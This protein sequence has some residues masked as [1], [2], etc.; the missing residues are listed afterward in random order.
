MAAS[1]LILLLGVQLLGLIAATATSAQESAVLRL[2]VN[3]ADRGDAFAVVAPDGDVMLPPT[4]TDAGL[5]EV[6]PGEMVNGEPHVSLRSLGPDVTFELD[7]RTGTL[8]LTVEPSRFAPTTRDYFFHQPPPSLIQ[9]STN[10]AF[11]NYGLVVADADS[12]IL[13]TLRG[14]FEL[15]G[16]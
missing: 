9:T 3:T 10:S 14:I 5:R 12:S 1:E 6:P 16:P 7:A 2:L 11:L 4:L 8:S 13:T 15:R